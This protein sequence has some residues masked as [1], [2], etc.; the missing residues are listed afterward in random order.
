MHFNKSSCWTIR[1]GNAIVQ[2]PEPY[3]TTAIDIKGQATV[4]Q[5]CCSFFI[6]VSQ[7]KRTYSWS[8]IVLGDLTSPAPRTR[9]NLVFLKISITS[10]F[11]RT[12]SPSFSPEV[13]W[14]QMKQKLVW[15]NDMLIDIE[16][17]DKRGRTL[18]KEIHNIWT[19]TKCLQRRDACIIWFYVTLFPR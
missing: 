12:S 10:E 16:P 18:Q 15:C 5:V 11:L 1:Q 3:Y 7:K 19:I 8:R 17:C 6:T 14:Q 13:K 2:I 4:R 9:G